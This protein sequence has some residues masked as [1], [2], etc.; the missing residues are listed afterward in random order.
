MSAL[1][2][3]QPD[4]EWPWP[5]HPLLLSLR[6]D[7]AVLKSFYRS[8]TDLM[9]RTIHFTQHPMCFQWQNIHDIQRLRAECIRITKTYPF[10]GKNLALITNECYHKAIVNSHMSFKSV[11]M[12]KPLKGWNFLKVDK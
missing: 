11:E 5:P 3:Y 2:R 8:Y 1:E 10:I 9:T 6:I 12:L 4:S 7:N